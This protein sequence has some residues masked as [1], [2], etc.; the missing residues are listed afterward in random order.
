MLDAILFLS[1][2]SI[3]PAV[4]R[5]Y[6]IAGDA[7]NALEIDRCPI[8]HFAGIFIVYAVKLRAAGL[9]VLFLFGLRDLRA[10]KLL[11]KVI[12]IVD[13]NIRAKD[14]PR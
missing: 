7:A 14:L 10:N 12:R 5:P 13:L 11:R 6:Q 8:K 3:V 4:D 2:L 9:A 1:A